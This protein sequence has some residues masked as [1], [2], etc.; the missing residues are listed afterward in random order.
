MSSKSVLKHQLDLF[1]HG[2]PVP[3]ILMIA[4]GGSYAVQTIIYTDIS[5]GHL[6]HIFYALPLL[7]NIIAFVECWSVESCILYATAIN[8][9]QGNPSA[10][11]SSRVIHLP[12]TGSVAWGG[13]GDMSPPGNFMVG[14]IN[15]IV[16]PRNF[17]NSKKISRT[18]FKMGKKFLNSAFG[19]YTL[20]SQIFRLPQTVMFQ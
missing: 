20:A 7:R 13:H 3:R 8:Y 6:K 18:T 5:S 4:E 16:P 19:A 14:T 12:L 10:R 1:K 17:V 11:A 2:N 9:Q 15:V